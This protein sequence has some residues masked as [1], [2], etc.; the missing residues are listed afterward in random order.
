M[1]TREWGDRR[2]TYPTKKDIENHVSIVVMV[3]SFVLGVL[4]SVRLF[5]GPWVIIGLS[6]IGGIIE[7]ILLKFVALPLVERYCKKHHID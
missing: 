4:L 2:V 7:I 1:D 3:I 5:R 6:I